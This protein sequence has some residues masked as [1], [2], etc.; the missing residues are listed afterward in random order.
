M[1]LTVQNLSK[2][3]RGKQYILVAYNYD[4]NTILAEPMKNLQARTITDFCEKMYT[5]FAATEIA[6]HIW[7]LDNERSGILED[8]FATYE[9]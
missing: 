6:P 7:V 9:V 5:T 1:D 8:A 2:F 4:A 3:A